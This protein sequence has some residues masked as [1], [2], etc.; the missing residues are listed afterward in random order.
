MTWSYIRSM[1][2]ALLFVS[3]PFTIS[4]AQPQLTASDEDSNAIKQALAEW[5]AAFNRHDVSAAAALFTEDADYTNSRGIT[6][7]GRKGIEEHYTANFAGVLKNAER[8]DSTK[9]I[10]FLSRE[11]A[12]VQI[13]WSMTGRSDMPVRKGLIDWVM[14]KQSGH[15]LVAVSHES[16]FL[17]APGK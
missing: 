3:F 10:R 4:S 6:I 8:T 13:A 9:N 14:T 11:I 15:W 5:S 12:A 17:V 1:I 2:M 16:E 7:H